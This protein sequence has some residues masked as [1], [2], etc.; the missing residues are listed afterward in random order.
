MEYESVFDFLKDDES[1]YDIYNHCKSMEKE[2]ILESYDLSLVKGRT[3]CEKLI[4]KIAKNDS[5]V[6]YIFS[7]KKRNGKQYNPGLAEV[8][9]EC[10][11]KKIL[12]R[13]LINKY[14]DIKKYGDAGAH[15]DDSD[16]YDI[17]DCKKVHKWVFDIAI[18]CYNEFNYPKEITYFY[19]LDKFNY[20]IEIT[21]EEREEDLVNLHQNEVVPENIKKSYETK[22]IFLTVDSFKECLSNYIGKLDNI[23]DLFFELNDDYRYINDEN[24]NDILYNVD[25]E[26]KN[27]IKTDAERFSQLKSDKIIETLNELNDDLTFKDINEMIISASDNNQREVYKV[28]KAL[29]IDLVK[30]H[31]SRIKDEI[32][33]VPVTYID[34]NGRKIS[35][36]KKYQIKEDE[37]GFYL[38]NIYLDDD[39]KAAVQYNDKKPL[40]VNAGPGSGKTRILVERVVFLVNELKKDP[41]SILVITYTRKATQELK[42]RLINDTDLP[43]EVVNEIRIST[44]HGFCRHLIANYEHVP[45]NYLNRYGEK[46]LFFSKFKSD[47]GFENYAF[48]YDFWIPDVLDVYGEY[49]NF[50]VN[51]LGL[52]NY[53]KEEMSRKEGYIKRFENYMDDFYKE[54]GYNQ[55]PDFGYLIQ[56]GLQKGSYYHRFL[57]IASSYP[58]YKKLLEDNKSCDD[59]YVLEKAYNLLKR[60]YVIEDISYKNILI[61][62]FQDT[63]YNQMKIFKKLLEICDFSDGDT[64][65]IVGDSDQSIYGWRGSNPKFFEDY[66]KDS[67]FNCITIHKNYRSSRNIVEFNEELIKN[68]R[69][70]QKKLIPA[71]S[72]SNPVFHLSSRDFE[73]D[74]AERIISIIKDLKR[75]KTIKYYSDVA[76]LFRL[77]DSI[78]KFIEVFERKGIP[79][80]LT[81]NNDFLNQNEV[82]SMLTLFWLLMPYQKER[83]VYR[84]D[85]FLNLSWLTDEYFG[86]SEKTQDIL[87]NIQKNFE[88]NVIRAASDA[89][90]YFNNRRKIL[91]YPE[92][93]KQDAKI[94]NYI[95]DNVETFDIVLLDEPDLIKLGIT[96]RNDLEFFSKLKNLKTLMWDDKLSAFDKPDTSYIFNRLLNITEYFREV[97]IRGDNH[98]I[99]VKDNLAL[100][101]QI[102]NDYESI[103]GNKNYLGL[104][105]YLD[106]VLESY[107]CRR[108]DANEGFNK[109]HLITMHSA[110]G[111][112][113][114]AV[115]LCSLK[116]G[117]CPKIF[118]ER[119]YYK[120]PYK[121]F[122]NKPKDV[123]KYHRE[124]EMRLIYVAATRAKDL[125]ILSSISS[126]NQPPAFLELL[127]RNR[128][129][130]IQTLQPHNL[131]QI[132]KIS[133][134]DIIEEND[135]IKVLNLNEILVDYLFCPYRYDILNNTRFNVNIRNQRHVESALHNLIYMIHN[136]KEITAEEVND[137]VQSMIKYHNL[138]SNIVANNIIENVNVYWQRY[139]QNYDVLKSNISVRKQMKNCDIKGKVD[140]VVKENDAEISIVQFIGSDYK[141]TEFI[142]QYMIC[143][144]FYVSILKN[145]DEFKNYEFKNII[146]HSIDNNE[147]HIMPYDSGL[148]KYTMDYL[149]DIGADIVEDK[150][151]KTLSRCNECECNGNHC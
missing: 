19:G 12:K 133:S 128:N 151:T 90:L 98:S 68:Q 124:E 150:F 76:L 28:I 114:P 59:D 15:G 66:V 134:S 43:I 94:L 99:K 55:L 45:Y 87:V 34:E 142:D 5:R 112:E 96:N 32:E 8:L 139:G 50:E 147:I 97:S 72:Y 22:K 71:K 52:V 38:E 77:K 61:D 26:L 73:N 126:N 144:Y 84:S 85:D 36:H 46:S 2:I 149:E 92:V 16:K 145:Y 78:D 103:M 120:T 24:I 20:S 123:R 11:D 122:A 3:V 58:K 31:L 17:T 62:E 104:F 89:F 141:I 118:K 101:S 25:D 9:G 88:R 106:G 18:N 121:F 135:G 100:F 93:F 69:N 113:Y 86:L 44:V 95:F 75:D 60:D 63:D 23:E 82:K 146:L 21:P 79:Y 10:S 4:K 41:S 29:S 117:L 6:S 130:K 132:N 65:T 91:K 27:K 48:L 125:L 138:S 64:F 40:V 30:N 81:E 108:R 57:N 148:E 39:Q 14:Y 105:N 37:N 56:K 74:E 116:D 136:K 54:N 35:K 129:V 119:K 131:S 49:F 13:N 115:I 67:D 33:D 80:Y 53:V 110:K 70:V 140:L 7:K 83:F 1:F 107:S 109:V 111:L 137:K 47:L 102:I 127:K 42:N 51:T 143:L